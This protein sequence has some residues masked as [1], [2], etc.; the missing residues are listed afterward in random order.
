M[1]LEIGEEIRQVQ[2]D[3]LITHHP[4]YSGGYGLHATTGQATIYAAN[5]AVGLGR[6]K[7]KPRH[8]RNIY[9]MNPYLVH[10]TCGLGN[11]GTGYPEIY[12]D[13]TDVID[14]K[15]EALNCIQSQYYGGLYSLKRAETEDGAHGQMIQIAYA[16]Q[17]QRYYP[18]VCYTL[19][20]SF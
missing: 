9:F 12:V 10:G 18:S 20:I 3:M 14:K 15:I 13:I 1:V 5:Y 17:F 11:P 19:P 4:H 16:E 2:P 8:I 7:T 6:S